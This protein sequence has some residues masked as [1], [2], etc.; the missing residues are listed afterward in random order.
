MSS[1]NRYQK[2]PTIYNWSIGVQQSLPGKFT[3]DISYV[4]NTERHIESVV[5]LNALPAGAH[6]APQNIDPTTGVSLPD[7]LI[8]PY[9]EY[10]L[11]QYLDNTGTANYHSLQVQLNRRYAKRPKLAWRTRF[12]GPGERTPG[13]AAA[14]GAAIC[15][16]ISPPTWEDLRIV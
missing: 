2:V 1:F 7:N 10:A 5:D 13:P 6:F 11:L 14:T 8:R 12:P 15:R 3:A 16:P 4:A 9:R